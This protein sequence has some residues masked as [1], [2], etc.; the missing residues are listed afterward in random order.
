MSMISPEIEIVLSV[1]QA[2]ARS[3]RHEFLTTEHL[4][5]ALLL[6][7]ATADIV[8]Q[9][10]GEPHEL[11]VVVEDFLQNGLVSLPEGPDLTPEPTMAFR[12]VLQ[13]AATHI[14]SSGKSRITGGDMLV[15]LYG[16]PDSHAVYFLEEAGVTRFNVV[17]YLAH[18]LSAIDDLSEEID[19]DLYSDEDE[20]SVKFGNEGPS[21]TKKPLETFTINLLEKA[22]KG[23]I[24]PIIGRESELKSTMQ[25]LCRRTKNNPMY[26]G[27][28]GV[29]KTALAEGLALK[30]HERKVPDILKDAE[31][32]LLDM[33]SLLAGTRYRGDFEQ[34]LKGVLKSLKKSGNAILFIDEI[35]TIVGAGATSG[36]SMDASNILK[37]ALASGEIRFIGS[38]TYQ[39]YRNYFEK[40]RALARR[41][42]KIDIA[43][44]AAQE[45]VA[46]LKGLKPY[47][48]KHHGVRY[49]PA[50]LRTA[51]ELSARYINDRRLPD[52]A[53]D[54]IDEAGA[55]TR[56]MTTARQKTTVGIKDIER[57]VAQTARIPSKSVSVTDKAILK[58][59]DRDLKLSVFGQNQAIEALVA[60]IKLSRAGLS[61]PDKPVGSFLFTGPTGV[62][63]TEVAKQL[64]KI[65]GVR[66]LRFDM[67]EYMERHAVSRLIGAPPGYVGFD[68]GGLLT[69]AIIQN[70]YS[71]LLL[72]E[73]EKAHQDMFSILLQVMD[74]ATLTDNN[75][76]KADFRNV[77]II[78]TSNVGAQELA[79]GSIGFAGD[80]KN[81]KPQDISKPDVVSRVVKNTF[82]PEFRNRLDSIIAFNRLSKETMEQV[83]D[84]FIAELEAQL[85]EKKVTF[86]LSPEARSWLAEN[87]HDPAYGAR[88]LW[89]LIQKEIRQPLADE[90]LFGKLE[91]GGMLRI[92]LKNGKIILAF[93]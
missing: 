20:D 38:T 46:I 54:V 2:E 80:G 12:R 31:L 63:K 89:R 93:D 25:T 57:I 37:P 41:F 16:E 24:D 23:L 90:L 32:Y 17:N 61:H 71:V 50:A 35:H 40:D 26:V 53:I 5:F 30:I 39:E 68:Q 8:S 14:Q 48:E 79:K 36:G 81:N 34:R 43:E 55:A 45:A 56:L 77:I 60:S 64:A 88:P 4:L 51:V 82:S 66:F 10:G 75:G 87:G 76:K 86:M 7:E 92:G 13:R 21:P 84:K 58:N 47:Y 67:S 70:P 19:D 91:K 49:T 85:S 52:K 9:V 3:K 1:A 29:G 72:D 6:D 69:D 27:D 33:G 42:H 78:M 44:P 74:Y 59:L 73:V 18:G 65:M 11:K 83:V 28:P 62:G 22:A 15:A